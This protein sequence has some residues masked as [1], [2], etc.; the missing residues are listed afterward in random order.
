MGCGIF[1][2]KNF[3]NQTV[4][5]YIYWGLRAQNHRGQ[6]SHGFLT[7]SQGQFFSYKNLDIVPKIK[8]TANDEWIERLPG[9]VGMGNVRYTTSGKCDNST[10]IQGT[11]PVI[12][13]IDSIEMAISFNGS[14]INEQE[15]KDKLC[16]KLDNFVHNCDADII[17]YELLLGFKQGKDLLGAVRGVM[18]SVDGA[19]SVIGILRDG[20][21]FAF[22]DPYG[23]K[24][25][26]VGYSSDRQTL[27]F[28]SETVGLDMNSFERAFEL[29]P[30]EL[31]IATKEGF[32]RHQLIEGSRHAFCAFEYAYFARP[33]SQ[34]DGKYVYE[35]R[36]AFGRN[37]VYENPDVIK[38]GDIIISVPETGDD[39]AMGVHEASGLRW[40]RASRR[41][42][43][44][45]ERA[46]ISLDNERFSTIDKKINILGSKVAGKNV[47]ICEDS[48]VRGD[49][50]KV[51]IDKLRKSGA[52]KIFVFATYPRVIG[53][54]FY[55]V[56][57]STYEQLVGAKNSPEEIAKIIGADGVCYLS[58]EKVV[59]SIGKSC[60]Q[61]CLACANGKYPT[62]L[63]Q[64]LADTMKK[65]FFEKPK[66]TKY[67]CKTEENI[68]KYKK[69]E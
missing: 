39:P 19:F 16:S 20:T 54:C 41:H 11:Q 61:L 50:T 60:D 10:I 24:P 40:E 15:L 43:Y 8:T 56:D 37:I 63:A 42:R 69:T 52:K 30:G 53:P 22:K 17:C 26:C 35:V 13:N 55:G 7:F 36:E 58:L 57:M 31:V 29:N 45:T 47:I 33:D 27:V 3:N 18:E 25:L 48:I 2:V 67:D 14:I 4:F 9:S 6:Q 59:E 1:G 62:P 51:I 21:I 38:E 28:S 65:E 46:F 34:F 44:I 49:T 66:E 32:I 5:P 23:I 12:G 68:C 64:K